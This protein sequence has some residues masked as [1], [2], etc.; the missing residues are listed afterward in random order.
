VNDLA[1]KLRDAFRY[2]VEAERPS[3]VRGHSFFCSPVAVH[4]N[5]FQME[6]ARKETLPTGLGYFENLLKGKTYF[7]GDQ[8]TYADF[9]LYVP[10]N[11]FCFVFMLAHGHLCLIVCLCDCRCSWCIGMLWFT[12]KCFRLTPLLF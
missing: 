12:K 1:T 2:P 11:I 4:S 5:S 9:K 6:V 7:G 3:K 10:Y 8:V